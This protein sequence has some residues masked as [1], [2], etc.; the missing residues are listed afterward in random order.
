MCDNEEFNVQAQRIAD[1]WE[2]SVEVLSPEVVAMVL[3]AYATGAEEHRRDSPSE[4]EWDDAMGGVKDSLVW[5]D[6]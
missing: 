6:L 3:E 2:V 1:E 5:E 4:E